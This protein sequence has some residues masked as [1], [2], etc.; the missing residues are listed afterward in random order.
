MAR[1]LDLP[2]GNYPNGTRSTAWRSIPDA[3]TYAGV[4]L[5]RC[6]SANPAIWPNASTMVDLT[7]DISMDG[8]N[9]VALSATTGQCPGGIVPGKGGGD[10]PITRIALQPLPVGTNRMVRITATVS[11]GPIRTSGTVEIR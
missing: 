7:I 3:A 5:A 10:A 9:T 2:L 8:G 11:G 4:E 1:T 6:T